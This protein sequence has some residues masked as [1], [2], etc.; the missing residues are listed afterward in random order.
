MKKCGLC[1]CVF[2]VFSFCLLDAL[3]DTFCRRG[4]IE[5][6]EICPTWVRAFDRNSTDT[7]TTERLIVE[8]N[9]CQ[10]S[11]YE[12][13]TME[14]YTA[15]GVL[16][17]LG[18]GDIFIE[19]DED[20]GHGSRGDFIFSGSYVDITDDTS[21][22]VKVSSTNNNIINWTLYRVTAGGTLTITD[23]SDSEHEAFRL[24]RNLLDFEKT[25]DVGDNDCVG[26]GDEFTYTICWEN[27]SDTTFEDAN[28]VDYLPDGVDYDWLISIIPYE[29]DPNYSVEDHTYTWEL[30]TIAP[31][32]SGCVSLTVTV[33]E[34]A[35]PGMDMRNMAK[36]WADPNIL[37]AWHF[38]DTP[39]CCWVD[40]PN[41]IYV[42]MTAEG[43]N[44]GIDWTNAY[45]GEEGLQRALSRANK[46]TCES[47]VPYTIYV[48]EGIYSP[49]NY[50]PDSFRLPEGSRVYG[51]FMAGGSDESGRNPYM[52]ET[53]L[54]GYTYIDDDPCVITYYE[55]NDTVV[56]MA[57]EVASDANFPVDENTLLDGFT[58]TD[59]TEYG[60]Y[61]TGVDFTVVNCNVT[62][63]EQ[64]GIYATDCDVEIKWSKV[65]NN[66][67]H[68]I[69]HEGAG[70]TIIFEN[71]QIVSN[72]WNG[73]LSQYS[74]PTIKNSVVLGNGY[75][76]SGF[77]GIKITLPTEVPVLYNNTI[78][79]NAKEGIDWFD[80]M[81][82]EGDP[83]LPDYPDI[84]NCILY[85][86]NDGGGQVTGFSQDVCASYCDIE[87]GSE[88]NNNINDA[89]GFMLAFDPEDPCSEPNPYH[90]HLSF[91]SACKDA[92]NPNQDANDLDM[93]DID[94]ED[95]IAN[96][97]VDIGADENNLCD[98]SDGIFNDLDW[99]L[100]GTVDSCELV[101]FA[102]AW[103]TRD[104]N[105]PGIITDPNFADDPDYARPETLAMWRENWDPLYNLDG[106]YDVDYGD[107]A[108]F[109]Q[110]WLWRAC[111]KQSQL[112]LMETMAM[113]GGESMAMMTEPVVLGFAALEEE[114]ASEPEE[115]ELSTA[116][117]ASLAE[118]IYAIIE[119]VDT[120]IEEGHENIEELYEMKEFLEGVL[121]DL[122]A[123]R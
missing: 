53:V 70:N 123:E 111:W 60:I 31:D 29:T 42:D 121:Q 118:G 17:D 67:L 51:G 85:Y 33:N 56:T 79:Y 8:L 41:I 114:T 107:F 34:N 10:I 7:H 88:V 58:I 61:G 77:D 115:A 30:G 78:I 108:V 9:A 26:P 46:S 91:D 102:G 87:G 54:T 92:G 96:A 63:S 2:G 116:E 65:N 89:P 112:D 81:N 100:D 16:A 72:K 44:S 113:G 93:Y 97:R 62:D 57:D 12:V 117:L 76:G 37:V 104:P 13:C 95:R 71:S 48:A 32:D 49:G 86:N 3:G 4:S 36:L 109:A 21:D 120:A 106:D 94:G 43:S 84:Q 18:P 55:Y 101:V 75:D 39:V 47:G 90:Y 59:A 105:D 73:L 119:Y 1:L 20:A 83:N 6:P 74:T 24:N 82:S 35:E 68:G 27:T 99:N 98:T 19:W 14:Q 11:E 25:D 50:A 110:E 80:D 69:E 103:L 28:I 38:L 22:Y 23:A 45:S 40:D 52:F 15:E 122:Q 66:G 5:L 64:Q